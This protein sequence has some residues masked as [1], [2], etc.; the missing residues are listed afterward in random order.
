M[1]RDFRWTRETNIR[2]V[3]RWARYML[4]I[5]DRGIVAYIDKSPN[6]REYYAYTDCNSYNPSAHLLGSYRYLEDAK[7]S[8]ERYYGLK[9]DA[10][11]RAE[12]GIKGKLRPFGL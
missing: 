4:L 1:A 10:G 6:Y 12:Y 8:I 9:R 7:K 5:D 2:N 11:K 3:D